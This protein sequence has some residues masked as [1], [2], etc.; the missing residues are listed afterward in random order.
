MAVCKD[1]RWLTRSQTQPS[2]T[3]PAPNASQPSP[4]WL[5]AIFK[6]QGCRIPEKVSVE[7]TTA[8]ID[9]VPL[10]LPGHPLIQ[11]VN[12]ILPNQFRNGFKEMGIDIDKF[13]L[14]T[15]KRVHQKLLHGD[16]TGGWMGGAWN[17]AWGQFLGFDKATGKFKN[18]RSVEDIGKFASQLL[19]TLIGL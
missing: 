12:H 17:R 10:G 4:W 3:A 9:L 13:M 19:G 6:N 16:K 7:S 8:Y 1:R 5:A 15:E 14:A 2:P 18:E 11:Q